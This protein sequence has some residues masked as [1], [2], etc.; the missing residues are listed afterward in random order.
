MVN[1]SLAGGIPDGAPPTARATRV[2]YWVLAAGCSLALLTYA[3][4]L[5]FAVYAP[6]IK[7]DFDLTDQG[8]AYLMTAFLVTYGIC[9]VPAGLAGDR[10][11]ARLVLP[12]LV[13]GWSL[14]TAAIALLPGVAQTAVRPRAFLL[15]PLVLLLILRALF[16]ASQS[17]AFPV[18]TRVLADWMPL[19]ERASAQGA[20]WT[21][22]R[23]GGA[24]LPFVLAW[25]PRVFGGWRVPLEIL[26]GLGLLWGAAFWCWF[27]NRPE[28][29]GRVNAAERTLIRAGQ[30]AAADRP[31]AV[32]WRRILGS[33]NVWFLCLMYGS[34]GPAGNF[35]FTL[36]PVYL[37]DHRHLPPDTVAWLLGLPL[38]VGFVACSL[39]GVVSDWLIRRGVSRKWGRRVNGLAGLALAGLAFAAMAW[40]EDG[41]LLGLVLCATQFG[42]DFCM[43]PAWAACA[44]I[45]EGSAGTISGAM[46][47]TSNIAGGAGAALAGYLFVRG[48]AGWVFVAFGALWMAGALC[49][50]GIDVTKPLAT[51]TGVSSRPGLDENRQ[52]GT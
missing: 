52:R 12:L 10:L 17:G 36:L 5:G 44:D 39:G 3:H 4:R 28:D 31:A 43:G 21:A 18:F 33:R 38:A 20:I 34:C 51:P 48:H 22:S 30:T 46:N 47:M 7:R 13:V 9:Q 1:A 25:L 14:V 41:W 49:W 27:R 8:V 37:R 50:L 32:P 16:G 19:T 24:L 40:V 26:S 23:L 15:E 29:E 35:I 42:N 11:G 45:G 6:E 2:R